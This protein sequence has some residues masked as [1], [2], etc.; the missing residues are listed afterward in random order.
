MLNA[1]VRKINL[2]KTLSVI[3]GSLKYNAWLYSCIRCHLQGTV[4]DIGSGLGDIARQINEPCVE[5]VILSDYDPQM[6]QAL[7]LQ[8]R[9]IYCCCVSWPN[10]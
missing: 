10:F 4:L 3:R 6:L 8:S 1:V 2:F 7:K 9:F 5:E